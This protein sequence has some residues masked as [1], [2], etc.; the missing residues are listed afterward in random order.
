[1]IIVLF[2]LLRRSVQQQC[3]T[4]SDLGTAECVLLTPHYTQYQ[5]A[6]CLTEDYIMRASDNAHQCRS[7]QV[8]QCYYQCM[9]EI[10]NV[11]SGQ[12]YGDCICSPGQELT[13]PT[14]LRP[15]CYSPSGAN[16]DWY[17]DCLEAR[18]ACEGTRY[19]Y[20]IEYADKFCNLY[21]DNYNDFSDDAREWID[22]VRKCL[23]EV[24]QCP[25]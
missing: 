11:D 4:T 18:Y 23:Q 21:V 16:C 12:V 1:V 6:T 15:E 5:W 8:T 25:I 2:L 17:R 7:D 19:G 24:L 14:I 3:S 20:A 22:G 10:Y 9:I 13:T